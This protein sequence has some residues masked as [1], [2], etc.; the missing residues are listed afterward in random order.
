MRLVTV[1][2][3][4]ITVSVMVTSWPASANTCAMP[5]PISPAPTTAMRA[6]AISLARRVAAV[7]VKDVAGVKI[8]RF[9][10]QEEQR[11]GE[12]GRLAEAALGH[13]GDE[14]LAHRGGVVVVLVH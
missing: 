2:R 1:S 12:V 4:F 8:R 11:A 13:A 5:C 3:F 10:G 7:G 9:R 14:A 6:F